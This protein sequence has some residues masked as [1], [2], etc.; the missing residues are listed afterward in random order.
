MKVQVYA[1]CES[2]TQVI[3]SITARQGAITD[4]TAI[5]T[6]TSLV[7]ASVPLRN[8]FGYISDLRAVTQGHG[9][10]SMEF[11][12]YAPMPSGDQD[13]FVSKVSNKK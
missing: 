4:A 13:T 7:E 8:M 3:T 11:L 2:Q 5:S 6:E 12:E 9:E 10:Y 1:P